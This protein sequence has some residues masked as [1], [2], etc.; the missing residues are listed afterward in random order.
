MKKKFPLL[1]LLFAVACVGESSARPVDSLPLKKTYP[2]GEV[3]VTGSRSKT[4]IRH[5]PMTVSVVSREKLERS[6]Q[7]SILPVL[8]QQ[9]PGLFITGRGIMGYSVA[10]GAAGGMSMRGIGGSPTTGMLVL[11]DGHPQYMGLMGHPIAD[12]YQ[13]FMT[14]RVEVLRGPASVLYGSNAMGGVINIVTRKMEKDGVKTNLKAGYGSYNT[15]IS[16]GTNRIR[17]G[18]FTS[19]LSLSYNRTDG[20]RADMEYDQYGGYAKLGYELSKHWNITG[21]I[22]LTHFNAEN[23]GSLENPIRNGEA[24][25]TRGMTSFALNN[26]Y[27]HSSGTLSLFYN[28]GHH[29]INDGHAPDAASKPFYFDGCDD[30]LGLS[31]YQSFTLFRGNRFT[32]GV[33]YQHFGGRA[34]NIFYSDKPDKLLAD[35][36]MDE[37]AG[38]LDFRQTLTR[39]MILDAGLRLDYHSHAGSEW[40]PQAGLSFLLP[41]NS[42][43]KL[44]VS[45]GFR[46]PTIREMYMFP[47]QNPDLKPE[48]LMNYE[49]A[50]TQRL[51]SGKLQ[52]GVNVFL[53]DG[54][55]LIQT[56]P[57]DGRPKN[58]NTGSVRNFGVEC[59]LKW[60][61]NRYWSLT[62]NYSYLHMKYPV[63][64]APEHKLY[65]GVTFIRKR[66]N[67]TTGVQYVEGL[68]TQAKPEH[69]DAF[70]LWD[71]SVSFRLTRWLDIFV[72]GDNLLGQHY[73]INYG[74]PMPKATAMGGINI[75][76]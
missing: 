32:V 62:A 36:T 17:K 64:A 15:F 43:L 41:C 55:N 52:Y 27:A 65:G 45:K 71:A 54:D 5:L 69:T 21:D 10:A 42:Q 18:R 66:W 76:F 35:K 9:V 11:I 34:R 53:I 48:K 46:F 68:I 20:H 74:Y 3:V 25:I 30:M 63:V 14:E 8:T 39:W 73:Q 28:W 51:A 26:E 40:I 31:A 13:T 61:M 60:N 24:R 57:V 6:L 44:M 72:K 1:L 12:A 75:N 56:L 33:D 16:E 47:P 49:L 7:P 22:N 19:V 2:I 37:V 59:D 58:V 50:F 38:Y 67:F 4:D 29:K 70:V 23:P